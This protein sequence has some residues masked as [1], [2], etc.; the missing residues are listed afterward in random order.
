MSR[1]LTASDRRRL[2]R[3]AS[4]M[5]KGSEG[6]RAI[7][8]GLKSAAKSRRRT[9]QGLPWKHDYLG[10]EEAV[11]FLETTEYDTEDGDIAYDVVAESVSLGEDAE[12]LGR[13]GRA[14]K[15]MRRYER[16]EP[17]PMPDWQNYMHDVSRV[18]TA[19]NYAK[20]HDLKGRFASGKTAARNDKRLAAA[21][22]KYLREIQDESQERMGGDPAFGRGGKYDP[23]SDVGV[24]VG[25][26][27]VKR[28]SDSGADVILHYDGG[29]YDVFSDYGDYAYMGLRKYRDHVEKLGEKYGYDVETLNNWSLGYYYKGL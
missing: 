28:Y 4:T 15:A 23:V 25:K 16:L 27:E 6:R 10:V 18:G 22:L 7:L 11:E 1:S 9:S 8:A 29:G 24:W 20:N 2:I 17:E 21:L 5:E 14:S 12:I 13:R 26:D 3:L 19:Q